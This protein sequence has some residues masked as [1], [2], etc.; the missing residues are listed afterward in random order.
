MGRLNGPLDKAMGE[1]QAALAE[2]T[3]GRVRRAWDNIEAAAQAGQACPGR[4]R[5]RG[6]RRARLRSRSRN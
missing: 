5:A 2:E 1:L 4:G 3:P 6:I